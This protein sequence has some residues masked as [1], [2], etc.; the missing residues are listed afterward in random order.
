MARKWHLDKGLGT[1]K[2]QYEDAYPGIVIG[3]IGDTAH[4]NEPSDHNPEEDGSVDAIDPMIG[5]HFTTADAEREV[6]ALV[7]SRDR[8]IAYIIWDRRIISSTVS[9]WKWRRYTRS[10]PHTGHFHLSVND[11]HETD[12]SPWKIAKKVVQV[13][14]DTIRTWHNDTVLAVNFLLSEAY[15]AVSGQAT[16]DS[17]E[18]RNARNVR[19]Y[20][21]EL[22][23]AGANGAE[24]DQV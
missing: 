4:Q 7:K 8:R 21:T 14:G 10:D 5:P 11:K 19:R 2:R 9:P 13:A 1:L 20:I 12:G 6:D 22:V 18:D 16:G 23:K 3:T 24:D 15:R 17:V